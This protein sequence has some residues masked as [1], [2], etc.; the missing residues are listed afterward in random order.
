MQH[1]IHHRPA[2]RDLCEFGEGISP[3]QMTTSV[4]FFCRSTPR[5][6][7]VCRSR[8][9]LMLVSFPLVSPTA[10][11][12]TLPADLYF[13]SCRMARRTRSVRPFA[14]PMTLLPTR[15]CSIQHIDI[16]P[17]SNFHNPPSCTIRKTM[18]TRSKSRGGLWGWR[19]YTNLG[20]I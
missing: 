18:K 2:K 6:R 12:A 9:T 13:T 17:S 11:K 8:G 19:D 20:F 5:P 16:N 3:H 15:K 10:R 7:S 4:A 14:L 1:T